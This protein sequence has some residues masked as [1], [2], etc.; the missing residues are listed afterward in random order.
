M[1]VLSGSASCSP[2]DED[3]VSFNAHASCSACSTNETCPVGPN[4]EYCSGF[5]DC[6]LGICACRYPTPRVWLLYFIHPC[7]SDTLTTLAAREVLDGV[8]ATK[9]RK[10]IAQGWA[11][12]GS[13]A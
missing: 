11:I 7:F 12:S 8:T 6:F 4:G 10:M 1:L 5:G 2:C 13:Y 3:R 9:E